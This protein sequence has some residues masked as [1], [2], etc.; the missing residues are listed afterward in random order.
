MTPSPPAGL[1]VPVLAE[2]EQRRR[3]AT[4]G[5]L[6][7]GGGGS[8]GL[9]SPRPAHNSPPRAAM[10]VRP[11]QR[12]GSPSPPRMPVSAVVVPPARWRQNSPAADNRGGAGGTAGHALHAQAQAMM[13]PSMQ[14]SAPYPAPVRQTISASRSLVATP[15]GPGLMQNQAATSLGGSTV[16]GAAATAVQ[17]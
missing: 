1:F 12:T 15:R 14:A 8:G 16:S 13:P 17:R 7:S 9:S 11:H 4:S 5:G 2:R 6:Q 10:Q 3:M